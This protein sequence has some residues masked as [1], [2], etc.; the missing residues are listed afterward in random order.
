LYTQIDLSVQI[1]LLLEIH[2]SPDI[3]VIHVS[4]M[5]GINCT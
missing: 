2:V 5:A 3:V 1:L 4:D